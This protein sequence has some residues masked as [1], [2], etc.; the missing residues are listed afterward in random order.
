MIN[1]S[2]RFVESILRLVSRQQLKRAP[3]KVR[4]RP[5]RERT[6]IERE[7]KVSRQAIT[8]GGKG[9]AMPAGI[10]PPGALPGGR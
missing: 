4:T 6:T 3:E 7:A 8:L 5:R 2:L 9:G 10:A 1:D